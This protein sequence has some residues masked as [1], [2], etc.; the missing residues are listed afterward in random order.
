[1]TEFL[2]QVAQRLEDG[3]RADLTERPMLAHFR[4]PQ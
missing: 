2:Q 1:M 4:S 3:R